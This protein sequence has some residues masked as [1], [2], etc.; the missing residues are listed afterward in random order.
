VV[1]TC[2]P[3]TWEA[4]KIISLRL[5]WAIQ[6]ETVAKTTAATTTKT[7]SKDPTPNPNK[8]NKNKPKQTKTKDEAE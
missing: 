6:Q 2:N 1:H 4:G 8:Q 3:S 7:K 5:V